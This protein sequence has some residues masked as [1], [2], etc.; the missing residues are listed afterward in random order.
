MR[1]RLTLIFSMAIV[2]TFGGALAQ[3]PEARYALLDRIPAPDGGF[4]YLSVDSARQRLFIGRSYGVAAIDLATRT[5][6]GKLVEADDVAA[7]LII[8]DTDR[9]LVTASGSNEALLI[10]RVSGKVL[11][12]ILTGKGPDAALYDPS[13]GHALVM[14]GES[15]D[16]SVVDLAAARVVATIPL[17][18]KPESGVADG[19]GRVFVNIEDTAEIAVVDIRARRV[20]NRIPL[21]GCVEPTGMAFDAVTGTLISAC[22]NRIAKLIDS[23]SG[24][25]RG[26]VSIGQDSD[27]VVFDALRRLVYVSCEDG[28]LVVFH[29][30]PQARAHPVQVVATQAGAR[31]LALDSVTGRVYL[32]SRKT[33]ANGK[34]IPGTFNILVVGRLP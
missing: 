21:S 24:A 34:R 26:S 29:L 28:T 1:K 19:A 4:D 11:N 31:T 2:S 14:N 6:I 12:R 33:D 22:H 23:R 3:S 15:N 18:G 25:D 30:D 7:V 32:A 13:T 9:M 10:N 5:V 8:P 16:A 17:G 20:L 27:G